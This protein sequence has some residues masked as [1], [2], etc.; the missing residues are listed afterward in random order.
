[1]IL[2]A[3]DTIFDIGFQLSFIATAGL[4]YIRPIFYSSQRIKRILDTSLVGE[5]IATTI[6]AQIATLPILFANFGIYSIWSIMVNTLVLWT[7][8]ILMIIGAVGGTLGLFSNFAGKIFIFVS[9]PLLFYFEKIVNLFS[10][11]R[12]LL[13]IGDLSWQVIV[14]YYLLLASL[15]YTLRTH[16]K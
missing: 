1:M 5:D 2:T 3:P 16:K 12:G 7:V 9:F 10:G 14:G 6:S 11:F 15:I 8:P 4:L 13:T